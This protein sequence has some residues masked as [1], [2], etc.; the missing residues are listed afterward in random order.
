MDARAEVVQGAMAAITARS[1]STR[2]ARSTRP[3]SYRSTSHEHEY[4]PS[5][6]LVDLAPEPEGLT[7]ALSA[8]IAEIDEPTRLSRAIATSLLQERADGQVAPGCW[9]WLIAEA[10]EA[11]AVEPGCRRKRRKDQ[12]DG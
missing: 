12:A 6:R 7:A 1:R 3:R 2:P 4:D 5:R 10:V 8:I 11:G 9:S